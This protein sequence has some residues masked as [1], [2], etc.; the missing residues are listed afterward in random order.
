MG[1]D[2]YE[3]SLMDDEACG[4]RS[5]QVGSKKQDEVID[6]GIFVVVLVVGSVQNV[7]RGFRARQECVLYRGQAVHYCRAEAKKLWIAG[8]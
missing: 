6:Q 5:S 1:S 2:R 4:K 7:D 8:R 3:K